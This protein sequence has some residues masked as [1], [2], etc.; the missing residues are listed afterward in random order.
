MDES[1]VSSGI[2]WIHS[3]F[4]PARRVARPT[5]LAMEALLRATRP[6][7]AESESA[8]P[9]MGTVMVGLEELPDLG[10]VG[11][12]AR[13]DAGEGGPVGIARVGRTS[14]VGFRLDEGVLEEVPVDF[15][16]AAARIVIGRASGPG[17]T[18]PA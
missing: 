9:A 17:E 16:D 4:N 8:P 5:L 6:R 18:Q 15:D 14:F 12:V 3:I 13:F 1:T 2:Q 7:A 10:E 11:G